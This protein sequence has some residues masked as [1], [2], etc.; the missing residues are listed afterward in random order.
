MARIGTSGWLGSSDWTRRGMARTGT[1]PR[2][3]S[4]SSGRL[5]T[6]SFWLLAHVAN[7]FGHLPGSSLGHCTPMSLF[8][9]QP[10]I[11]SRGP[12]GSARDC[13]WVSFDRNGF[14]PFSGGF[15]ELL[16]LFIF[17]SIFFFF[18]F[19]PGFCSSLQFLPSGFHVNAKSGWIHFL[20]I[21]KFPRYF[22]IFLEFHFSPSNSR[23]FLCLTL[24]AGA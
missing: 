15:L 18:F 8:S 9:C 2:K 21:K 7:T 23:G 22:F 11:P 17:F 20:S 12:R 14:A 3:M 4:F 6:P 1:C 19:V 24:K 13:I 5:G 16:P 10:G